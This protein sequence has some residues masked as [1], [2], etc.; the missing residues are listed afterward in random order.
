MPDVKLLL[1]SRQ[2]T[3]YAREMVEKREGRD[4]ISE[5]FD[6]GITESGE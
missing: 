2:Y 5:I 3:F 4:Y 6:G 1:S